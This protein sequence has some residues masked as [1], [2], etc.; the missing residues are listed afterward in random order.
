MKCL[1]TGGAGFIGSHL[2]QALL[3]RGAEVVILDNLSTGR[4]ENV[5]HLLGHPGASFVHGSILDQDVVDRCAGGCGHI[6]HLAAAVGVKLIFERPVHTIETNVHGTE[7]ILRAARRHGSKVLIASTSEVYGKDPRKQKGRFDEDDD[8]TLGTSLR[9]GYAASKALDEY[10]ARAYYRE[11]QV[12]IVVARFFNT[13]GPRQTGTYGMVLPRF[14][15]QCLAAR[16]LTVYG[17]GN[18]VRVFLW[19]A[20]AVRAAIE[21]MEHPQATGEIVNVGGVEPVTIRDL[22]LK[23][24]A[25]TGSRSEIVFVPYEDAYGPGF[26]DIHYRVPDTTRL[27]RFLDFESTKSLDDIILEVIRYHTDTEDPSH[28]LLEVRA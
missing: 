4:T 27:R 17:D 8:L 10:L 28:T 26:E 2:A 22:A 24:K 12:P 20:D 23:V 3:A 19:V 1:V 7:A 14:V 21:L 11:H 16:P 18:Q 9:W 25:L 6:Y 15:E 13:V 5:A